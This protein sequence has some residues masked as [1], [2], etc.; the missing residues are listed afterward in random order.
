MCKKA[1]KNH[2]IE[3]WQQW[4]NQQGH[5]NGWLHLVST[6][7]G[8]QRYTVKLWGNDLALR[9]CLRLGVSAAG[10]SKLQDMS[11]TCRFCES[12]T[13]ETAQHLLCKC[14]AFDVQRSRFWAA[15]GRKEV[16]SH[17]FGWAKYLEYNRASATFLTSVDTI[18]KA[19]TTHSLRGHIETL[20][21]PEEDPEAFQ[22]SLRDT[23][24]WI[25]ADLRSEESADA[26]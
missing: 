9:A 6:Q 7:W 17:E 19:K 8:P 4:R 10:A 1:T 26:H 23:A 16:G 11:S 18:F 2:D 13:F 22:S 3:L 24:R 12:Q 21:P 15:L 25:L 5:E 20:K 14:E